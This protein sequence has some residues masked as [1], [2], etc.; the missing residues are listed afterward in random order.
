V[1]WYPVRP[2]LLV[3]GLE[4][5]WV[6]LWQATP[7]GASVGPFKPPIRFGRQADLVDFDVTRDGRWLVFTRETAAGEVWVA[8]VR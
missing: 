6:T 8:E 4:G 2:L 7:A 3:S 1:K 5:E